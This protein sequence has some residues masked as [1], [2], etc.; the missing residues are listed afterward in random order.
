MRFFFTYA[1]KTESLSKLNCT[2][3]IKY[4]FN[5]RLFFTGTESEL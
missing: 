4:D 3:V 2:K 5:G 1:L